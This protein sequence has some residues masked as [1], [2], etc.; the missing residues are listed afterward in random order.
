MDEPEVLLF[1]GSGWVRFAWPDRPYRVLARTEEREG[2]RVITGLFVRSTEH[3]GSA[4]LKSLPI[5]WLEGVLN[6]PQAHEKLTGASAEDDR[7]GLV[8]AELDLLTDEMTAK[9]AGSLV[10]PGV[11]REPLQ[12]PDG[13]DP[14]MFYRRVAE[15]YMDI[16]RRTSAIAPVI[17]EEADV[18]VGTAR[19]W[20]QEARRRGF[21]PPARQGRAG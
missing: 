2:R 20:I 17:A 4:A 11:P 14:N 8:L 7:L 1:G 10:G 19:R 18:P 9:P 16:L 5:G 21:L 15:A 3:I 6:T 13:S 12:R